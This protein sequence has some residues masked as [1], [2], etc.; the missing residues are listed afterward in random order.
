MKVSVRH[1]IFLLLSTLTLPLFFALHGWNQSFGLVTLGGFLHSLLFLSF[2][3]C[4]DFIFALWLIK[5]PSKALL[6]CLFT[7]SLIFFY[8]YSSSS[9]EDGSD[10]TGLIRAIILFVIIIMSL[11]F[12]LKKTKKEFSFSLKYVQILLCILVITET[13]ILLF[14]TFNKENATVAPFVKKEHLKSNIEKLPSVY[15]ILLD[16]YAGKESTM[17]NL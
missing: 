2:L 1:K 9:Q 5:N 17:K 8:P 3:V 6:F 10:H 15:V 16:E 4:M 13:V 7:S 14:V 12:Y 11:F